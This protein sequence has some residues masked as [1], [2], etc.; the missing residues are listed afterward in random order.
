[1]ILQWAR[2]QST[3]LTDVEMTNIIIYYKENYYTYNSFFVCL[4]Y[5]AVLK[6][7]C[8]RTLFLPTKTDT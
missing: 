2:V 8:V 3:N 4:F 5:S 1:M 7:D 6:L